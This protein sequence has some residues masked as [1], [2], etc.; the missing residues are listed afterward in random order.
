MPLA[1]NADEPANRPRRVVGVWMAPAAKNVLSSALLPSLR[2]QGLPSLADPS[3]EFTGPRQFCR[4]DFLIEGS[5]PPN[6]RSIKMG[7]RGPHFYGYW[8][9]ERDSNPRYRF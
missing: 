5:N 7:A 9:R 4:T 8:R 2:T 1:S 6:T 3:G